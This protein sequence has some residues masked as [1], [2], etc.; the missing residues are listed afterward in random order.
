MN[1][2]LLRALGD[3]DE[4]FIAEA[5]PQA[6]P[7]RKRRIRWLPA[8]ACLVL[9]FTL[10]V[11]AL[12]FTEAG[13]RF[14]EYVRSI[15]EPGLVETGYNVDIYLE[16]YPESVFTGQVR[17]AGPVIR[18]QIL[19]Y[20]S[21]MSQLPNIMYRRFDTAAQAMEYLGCAPLAMP[22]C[23]FTETGSTVSVYG[24]QQGNM[25][26]V[27]LETGYEYQ[28][29]RMQAF[30]RVYTTLYD[31]DIGTGARD[32]DGD[33]YWEGAYTTDD[34]QEC[35]VMY[36]A[37]GYGTYETVDGYIVVDNIFYNL[38]VIYHD[39]QRAQAEEALYRWLDWF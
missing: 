29:L 8:A 20:K 18:Q 7:R 37:D 33:S 30:A 12:A 4:A 34:G 21:Y 6:S 32:L 19:N 23:G 9:V 25:L 36:S 13:V 2:Q 17:E 24:D 31:G 1:E 35:L 22:D 27:S 38:H 5:A 28:E 14:R 39:G 10:S 3:V 11:T 15:W 26:Q 16:K